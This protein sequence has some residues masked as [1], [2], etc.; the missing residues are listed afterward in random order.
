MEKV[1]FAG[2]GV[3]QAALLGGAAA[4]S[5]RSC[6]SRTGWALFVRRLQG[7]AQRHERSSCGR[8]GAE[9]ERTAGRM[10]TVVRK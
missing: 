6:R 3:P 7:P 2:S 4:C 1:K 9:W 5:P 10:M 8:E